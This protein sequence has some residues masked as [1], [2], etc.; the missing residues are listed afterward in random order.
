MGVSNVGPSLTPACGRQA[1]PAPE[2][3][4]DNGWLEAY[5]PRG[6]EQ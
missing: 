1:Q 3:L 2:G 5:C 6:E 4:E